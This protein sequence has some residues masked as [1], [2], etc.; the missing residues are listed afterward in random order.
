MLVKEPIYKEGAVVVLKM[1]SGE[2]IVT[3]VM[4]FD[5]SRYTIIGKEPLQVHIVRTAEG[6]GKQLIPWLM[7]APESNP[8]IELDKVMASI[9]APNEVEKAYTTQTSGIVLAR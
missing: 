9:V 1:V 5:A 3:K 6:P 7:L 4:E 2:E 8:T